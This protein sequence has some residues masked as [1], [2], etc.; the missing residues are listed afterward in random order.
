M[1]GYRGWAGSEYCQRK[2]TKAKATKAK[3]IA[4]IRF[5]DIAEA[6]NGKST[7]EIVRKIANT[8]EINRIKRGCAPTETRDLFNAADHELAKEEQLYRRF[9]G[10][11]YATPYAYWPENDTLGK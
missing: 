7:A 10:I 2:V 3:K 11:T 9:L 6:L 8:R 5:A 1:R 4:P